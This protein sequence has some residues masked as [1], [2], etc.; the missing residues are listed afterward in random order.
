MNITP[1]PNPTTHKTM[2]IPRTIEPGRIELRPQTQT[3]TAQL[4]ALCPGDQTRVYAARWEDGKFVLSEQENVGGPAPSGAIA[5]PELARVLALSDDDLRDLAAR[6]SIPWDK[7]AS[8]STMCQRI[9]GA[10]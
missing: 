8:R 2:D 4:E 6:R 10:K 3:D 5:D 9:A 1:T 7:K